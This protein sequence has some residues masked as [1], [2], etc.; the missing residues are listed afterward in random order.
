MT[1]NS[2]SPSFFATVAS[3][4]EGKLFYSDPLYFIVDGTVT[5][6]K[7]D[8]KMRLVVDAVNSFGVK[9]YIVYDEIHTDLSASREDEVHAVKHLQDGQLIIHRGDKSYTVLGVSVE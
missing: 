7:K 6:E 2:I 1:S 9:V 5:V 8:A 4:E 3:D